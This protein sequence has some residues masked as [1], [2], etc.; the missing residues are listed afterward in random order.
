MLFKKF[1]LLISIL[2]FCSGINAQVVHQIYFDRFTHYNIDDW[3]TF[4]P[5]AEITSIDIGDDYA[6]FGTRYG[7]ILR[8]HLYDHFW[9][10]PFTTGSG[11]RSNRIIKVVYS[12]EER[13]LFAQTPKGV[14]VYNR[15]FNYWEPGRELPQRR[16]AS[17]A[18]IADFLQQKDY[19]FPAYYRPSNSELPDFF[20]DFDYLF[21]PPNKVLDKHNR[22]FKLTD[23]V[24]D[25]W[26]NLWVG[27]TGLGIGKADLNTLD[28]SFQ[29]QSISNIHPRD[30][31]FDNQ[32]I[33]IAGIP[34][35][36]APAGVTLWDTEENTWRYFE[37]RFKANMYNDRICVIA[38]N[39]NHIFF[40][41]NT[42]LI[43][44]SKKKKKWRSFTTAHQLESDKINDLFFFKKKLFIATDEGFNWMG[45]G[46]RKISESSDLKL[47]NVPIYQIAA[48]DSIIL[49]ATKNGVYQY[50]P[51]NDRINFFT[52]GSSLLDI[53][54]TAID[55]HSDTLWLAGK[56]GVMCCDL[57]TEKWTS[58]TQV[59]QYIKGTIHDVAFTP[60]NVWFACDSGLLK[61]DVERNYWYLYTVKDGLADNRVYHIDVDEDY[62]WLSTEMGITIFKW[63]RHNR[64][65]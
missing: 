46:Y 17:E 56:Y 4:A 2:I 3:V 14:D 48:L 29:L 39:K 31:L 38:G 20:T 49:F 13:K 37:A 19:R 52:T 51:Q 6:Y 11:L 63:R 32:N 12:Y 60:G 42:G 5:A 7:G 10:D 45:P 57:R 44:Y 55:V 16:T 27:T 65:E 58:F 54:I 22:V 36:K 62:L 53:G 30:I 41:S 9:D 24:V 61:Y 35:G 1:I 8:Y 34:S 18:D 50:D 40:G 25:I 64:L 47:D 23:R 28:I 59:Q 15:A 33:W 43:K 26:E 21:Q